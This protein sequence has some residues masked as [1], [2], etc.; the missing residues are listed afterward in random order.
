MAFAER[1]APRCRFS[2]KEQNCLWYSGYSLKR[3]L[4]TKDINLDKCVDMCRAAKITKIGLS[5]LDRVSAFIPDHKINK[6]SRKPTEFIKLVS[7]KQ[8]HNQC[9]YCG[10]SMKW[11]EKNV[12]LTVKRAESIVNP[13]ISK[14]SALHLPNMAPLSRRKLTQWISVNVIVLIRITIPVKICG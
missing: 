8:K 14:I 2:Y 1:L 7:D 4:R 9:K 10:K 3:H 6:R 11:R 12:Q 5:V 13:T